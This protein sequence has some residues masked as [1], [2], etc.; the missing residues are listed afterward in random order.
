LLAEGDGWTTVTILDE[1]AIKG[2]VP[3]ASIARI[4]TAA[5]RIPN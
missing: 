3:Q 4:T 2:I 5:Q 1:G